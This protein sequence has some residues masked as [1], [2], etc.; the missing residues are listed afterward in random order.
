MAEFGALLEDDL[1]SCG[2]GIDDDIDVFASRLTD[3]EEVTLL[4]HSILL[5][6]DEL[7]LLLLLDEG[8]HL[9]LI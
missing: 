6:L 5:E 9:G 2:L 4:V 1:E 7:V 8:V 3:V